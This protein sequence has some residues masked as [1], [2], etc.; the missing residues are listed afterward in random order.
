MSYQS[1]IE[2]KWNYSTHLIGAI[3]V[4]LGLFYLLENDT[5]STKYST[6]AIVI[7]SF[8]QFAMFLSSALYHYVP[9]FDI[10]S[11]LRILDH[12]CIFL[13]IAGTYT[14]VCLISLNQGSGNWVL[15]FIW[16]I[17]I[18]GIVLKLFFT[19]KYQLLS[20]TVYV[21]MGLLIVIDLSSLLEKVGQLGIMYLALGGLSYLVGVLFY[22]ALRKMK[23]HHVIWHFFVLL[24]QVFHYIFIL[25]FVIQ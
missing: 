4:V 21:L 1:P 23:F 15:I 12:S 9:N 16:S 17:V 25:R 18:I 14:P 11:K 3:A 6:L 7:Y 2:E 10:K 20:V 8:C 19:G 5:H 24:G 13:S 22:A